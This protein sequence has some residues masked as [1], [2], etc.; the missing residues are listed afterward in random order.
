MPTSLTDVDAFTDPIVVPAPGDDR[1]SASVRTAL[2]GLANRT[3]NNRNRIAAHDTTLATHTSTLALHTSSL[4]AL[5]AADSALGARLDVL[6]AARAVEI[7]EWLVPL[8]GFVLVEE[9]AVP[10]KHR[11]VDV[12]DGQEQLTLLFGENAR[13]CTDLRLPRACTIRKVR[14]CVSLLGGAAVQMKVRWHGHGG[15]GQY[16]SVLGT[17][18]VNGS[19]PGTTIIE[20][21]EDIGVVGLDLITI[22]LK[23]TAGG[24]LR[25]F[26]LKLELSVRQHHSGEP[27]SL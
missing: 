14:A 20:S 4:S 24:V 17:E 25:V 27:V 13:M 8:S 26:W 18:V 7:V 2:E 10:P 12:G 23:Q 1:S 21:N 6:E 19:T 9:D 5:G 15:D 3:R 22:D 16:G 11:L